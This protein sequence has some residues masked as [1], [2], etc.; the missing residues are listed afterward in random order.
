[1]ALREVRTPVGVV[2]LCNICKALVP[3]VGCCVECAGLRLDLPAAEFWDRLA[4]EAANSD[5]ASD[6]E[7]IGGLVG[8]EVTAMPR[9]RQSTRTARGGQGRSF[10]S[11]LSGSGDT[12][13]QRIPNS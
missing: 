9:M 2:D 4:S 3:Y 12:G 1:M 10:Y 7:E 6:G 5:S 11:D 13:A 8:E